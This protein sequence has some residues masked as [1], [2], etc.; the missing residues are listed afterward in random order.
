MERKTKVLLGL[1]SRRPPSRP[2]LTQDVTHSAAPPLPPPGALP[3]SST[4]SPSSSPWEASGAA[5]QSVTQAPLRAGGVV[6]AEVGL[7][8]Q[9]GGA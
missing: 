5:N 7:E 3:S 1:T 9:R 4:T 2:L 6:S 8:E